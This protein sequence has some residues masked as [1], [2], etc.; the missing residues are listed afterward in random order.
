MGPRRYEQGLQ[1]VQ[2]LPAARGRRRPARRAWRG[3]RAAGR[4]RGPPHED[5]LAPRPATQG[6]VGR[7]LNRPHHPCAVAGGGTAASPSRLRRTSRHDIRRA[8]TRTSPAKARR[9][10]GRAGAP[11][12]APRT[13]AGH[14][15][16]DLAG[17]PPLLA[18][19][20]TFGALRERLGSPADIGRVGRH[21]GLVAVPHGAKTYLSAAIAIGEPLVWI[22]RDAEIGDRVAEE[23]GAWLG[24]AA[25]VAVLEP[26][27]AL[28]YERSELV[29]DETAARVAALA[30]WRSGQA[31]VLVASVQALLQHTIAPDDLPADPREL[32]VGARL[33]QDQLL[34]DLFDLGYTPVT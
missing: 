10:G 22:A 32:R 13:G 24:D 29:A 11:A 9:T 14:R 2:H 28:A 17:L 23:L 1:P 5:R 7:C 34:R 31:R 8:R 19:T 6:Q 16:P 3:R 12:A 21:A 26:R 33:H 18:E 4:D 20:G 27:T 25:T 15:L 30:T